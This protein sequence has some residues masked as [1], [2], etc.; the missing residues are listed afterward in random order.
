MRN[1]ARAARMAMAARP[2]ITPPAIAPAWFEE[3]GFGVGDGE[4]VEEVAGLEAEEGAAKFFWFMSAL[5]L[6]FNFC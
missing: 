5:T 6:G 1:A 3:G 2:P 4:E